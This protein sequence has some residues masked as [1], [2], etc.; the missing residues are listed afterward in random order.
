MSIP[1]KSLAEHNYIATNDGVGVTEY[2]GTG[3]NHAIPTVKNPMNQGP[4]YKTPV[5]IP[6][7]KY[8]VY[9]NPQETYDFLVNMGYNVKN[10]IP[11]TYQFA[12]IY[13]RDRGE[14]GV[15]DII[16]AAHPDKDMFFKAFGIKSAKE[17]SFAG[18]QPAAPTQ[19][20]TPVVK[21]I[22]KSSS[23]DKPGGIKINSNTVII[24]LVILL[25][26]FLITRR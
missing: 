11:S 21:V 5:L 16:R 20:T 10:D 13:I 15:Y 23:E 12:K 4:K 14:D 3:A 2:R 9:N 26:F 1:H 6:P 25:F 7:L 18:E 8:I 17:S 22:D 19:E 24:I